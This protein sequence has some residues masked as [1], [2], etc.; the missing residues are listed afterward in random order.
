MQQIKSVAFSVLISQ[1][2]F[3]Q[4]IKAHMSKTGQHYSY[5]CCG[6]EDC[7]QVESTEVKVIEAGKVYESIFGKT[8][9][10]YSGF[11]V[12]GVLIP[13][14]RAQVSTDGLYHICTGPNP[15]APVWVSG[16]WSDEFM[17]SRGADLVED[18]KFD[19]LWVPRPVRDR[20]VEKNRELPSEVVDGLINDLIKSNP[21]VAMYLPLF[22]GS[23][24]GGSVGSAPK[25]CLENNSC[26]KDPLGP[27]GP[28]QAQNIP[29]VFIPLPIIQM[30]T[31]AAM[32]ILF[33]RVF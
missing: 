4:S 14:E 12:R 16:A 26:F 15:N 25:T 28:D 1:S 23:G 6:G 5:V 11:L 2:L 33:K 13:A 22:Y 32:L 10:L 27:D 17:L 21:Q 3:T 20:L 31:W 24:G 29:P 7:R 8:K 18:R 9:A 30:V 19:C